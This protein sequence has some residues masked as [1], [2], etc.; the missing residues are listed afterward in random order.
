MIKLLIVIA[1]ITLAVALLRFKVRTPPMG[2]AGQ[3]PGSSCISI[4]P[5]P[6][7]SFSFDNLLDAIEWVESRGDADAVGDN[8][9]AVGA[10]QIHKIYV[11][12]VN[13]ILIKALRE[14][15]LYSFD[16]RYDPEYSRMM[17]EIYLSHYGTYERLGRAATLEDMAR[18]HNGGPNGWKKPSTEAYWEL[19]KM[20]MNYERNSS[21]SH[22]GD[23]DTAERTQG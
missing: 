22:A 18:I 7:P 13:R 1:F 17:V 20:R 16:H 10:Y 9:D 4:T 11:D 3:P 2:G 23:G 14:P 12:D 21:R 8:G 6:P 15:T 5:D 19:V